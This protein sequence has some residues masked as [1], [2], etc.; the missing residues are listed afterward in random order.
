[1]C[2]TLDRAKEFGS[3]Q[4]VVSFE[5]IEH[6]PKPEAFLSECY[7]I[8]E[9]QGVMILST[10]N[11]L[12]TSPDGKTNWEFHE[13]EYQPEE[14]KNL[15]LGAGFSNITLYGQ[16]YSQIGLFRQQARQELNRINSNPFMRLGR[17]IQKI[18]KGHRYGAT[19]PE[20]QEDFEII[21]ESSFST[22]PPF[23]ILA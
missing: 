19:L 13:K 7:S 18:L 21:P 9:D 23:V 10:P 6:L 2:H 5:T 8:L 1:D 17:F 4:S 14:L 3:F 11:S 12:V 16:A 20:Q 15:F 22:N